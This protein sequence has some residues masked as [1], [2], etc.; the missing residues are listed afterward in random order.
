[1]ENVVLSAVRV[2][3]LIARSTRY[4]MLLNRKEDVHNIVSSVGGEPGIEGIRIY[5][6][7]GEIIFATVTS[8]IY[9]TVDMNAEACISCHASEGLERPHS[10]S[11]ELSR[12]F[13][14]PNG[15]RVLG[16][17][18]PI[19]N[20]PQCANA[21]CHAH[22]ESKTILGVLDVKMTL[23]QVDK[24]LQESKNQSLALSAGAVLLI[25]L[26]SG[27][28]IW[29][30]VRRPVR[31]LMGGMQMVASGELGLRLEATSNDELGQL[32]ATFNRMTEDLATAREEITAWSN[33]LEQKV[34]EKTADLE[35]AH[36]QMVRVERMASLGNLAATVAHELNNP[37]EGILTFAKLLIKRVKKSSLPAADVKMFHDDLQLVADEA[38]RCGNIVKNLLVF[39][40]QKG[41]AFQTVRLKTIIDRCVLLM[42][43]HAQMHNVQLQT[44]G[45]DHDLI[46]CDPNQIQ[47]ALV[48]LMMNAI[49]AMSA[50]IDRAEGGT[51]TIDVSRS[52]RNNTFLI[53]VSDTG[54]GMTDEVRAHIFEPFFTTKSEGKGVGLGLAVV[55][56]IIERHNGT[57]NVE[58]SLGRGT[59]FLISLPIKQ[60]AT[61][62]QDS[63]SSP[64]EGVHQ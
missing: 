33:T 19:R 61:M 24:R 6:K 42:N 3:D 37:L 21:A 55:Y 34:G 1:M 32:A 9:K 53:R 10:S 8:D 64:G 58:T 63:I 43:H 26:I 13:T 7:Q 14:K 31:K 22:P 62:E 17:I 45:M 35:L 15:D 29:M 23:T 12:I 46:E 20:E 28:F 11:E 49:E 30:F 60:P 57:I 36:K 59:T 39:T 16:L 18:T 27:G 2:S 4:S 48:A 41:G 54:I 50:T 56:G 5:N 40:R 51:L 52:E 25:A 38:Q 47:Q 44:T